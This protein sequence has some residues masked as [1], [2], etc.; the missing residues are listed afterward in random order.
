MLPEAVNCLS[1]A[2]N[3]LPE[4]VNCLS[5][6]VNTLPEA[7]NCLS[8]AVNT[9]PEAVSHRPPPFP[10]FRVGVPPRQTGRR[11]TTETLRTRRSL[12]VLSVS[13]VKVFV[14]NARMIRFEGMVRGRLFDR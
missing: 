5:E 12:C 8:E 11:N 1:E 9:L 4:A 3:T 14:Q 6:A 7:V 13:V 10:S 2:V